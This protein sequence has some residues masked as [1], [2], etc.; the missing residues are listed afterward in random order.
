MR[1]VHGRRPRPSARYQGTARSGSP[2]TASGTA[3]ASAT[4][5]LGNGPG[6]LADWRGGPA[7]GPAEQFTFGL[8]RWIPNASDRELILPRLAQLLGVPTAQSLSREELFSGWRLFFER[9]AEH[10]PVVIVVEDLQWPDYGMVDF[11]DYL[12]D[13]DSLTTG[14]EAA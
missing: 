5:P 1:E 9:L 2:G 12:L 3:R 7:R 14:G 8:E 13:W 6:A 11:L 10:L 4:G